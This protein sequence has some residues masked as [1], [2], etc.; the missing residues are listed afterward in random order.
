M[1]RTSSSGE[2]KASSSDPA[3]KRFLGAG[4]DIGKP[5]GLDKDWA[6][7][8][9]KQVGNY[10]ESFDSN[11]GRASRIRLARGNMNLWKN[12]GLMFAPPLR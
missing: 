2:L 5:L 8:V 9:V 11:L 7:R 10:A 4:E 12:G 3:V 1:P 6:Y